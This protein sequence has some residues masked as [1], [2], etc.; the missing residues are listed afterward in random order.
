M[1]YL[2]VC[3]V[4]ALFF[5]APAPAVSLWSAVRVTSDIEV[6]APIE[7]ILSTSVGYNGFLELEDGT[8]YFHLP[9]RAIFEYR[10]KYFKHAWHGFWVETD[11]CLVVPA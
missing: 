5:A 3:A 9:I 11:Y 4:L 2:V 10:P 1:K 7:G 6:S 8:A